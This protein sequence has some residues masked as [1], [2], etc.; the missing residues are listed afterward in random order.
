M[1]S[2]PQ[3]ARGRHARPPSKAAVAGERVLEAV[4]AEHNR[5]KVVIAGA[6]T[7]SALIAALAALLLVP[8]GGTGTAGNASAHGSARTAAPVAAAS[9]EAASAAPLA[10]ADEDPQAVG[11]LRQKDPEDKVVK[12][13]QDVRNSGSYLRIYTDLP[14]DDENSKSAI[15]LCEWAIDYLKTARGESDPRVFVHAK[16]SDNGN[17]VLANKDS[18]KDNCRVGATR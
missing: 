9:P 17:V 4:L 5:R 10:D 1:S 12:H 6:G 11:Y 2:E 14:E 8:G 13:V 15:S 3:H 7:G 16:K 18:A